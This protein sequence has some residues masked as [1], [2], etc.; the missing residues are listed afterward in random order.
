MQDWLGGNHGATR[1]VNPFHRAPDNA[2][3]FQAN[4]AEIHFGD[5]KFVYLI[6]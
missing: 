3:N 6:C 2:F 5:D 1:V 4:L